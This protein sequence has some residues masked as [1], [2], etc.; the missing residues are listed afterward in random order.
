MNRQNLTWVIS[1]LTITVIVVGAIFLMGRNEV[2]AP[3]VGGDKDEHG[4]IGSAGYSWCELKQKCLRVWEEP[5]AKL[6]VNFTKEGNLTGQVNEWTLIYEETGKPALTQNLRFDNLSEC[7]LMCE[8]EICDSASLTVG[9]RVRVGGNIGKDGKVLV[10]SLV[11][12]N[13]QSCVGDKQ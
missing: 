9:E 8:K 13:K 6:E 11:Y 12:V 5:C 2:K 10:S 3:I 4:C 7:F 1:I